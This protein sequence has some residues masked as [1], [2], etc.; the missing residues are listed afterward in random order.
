[1]MMS[2][3][4]LLKCFI[5]IFNYIMILSINIYYFLYNVFFYNFI[6]TSAVMILHLL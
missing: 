4:Y 3:Q 5:F 2:L 1:M 6:S